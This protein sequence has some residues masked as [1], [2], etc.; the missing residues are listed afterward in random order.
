MKRTFCISMF[1]QSCMSWPLLTGLVGLTAG[2]KGGDSSF[3]YLLLSNSDPVITRIELSYQDSSIAKGT[4]TALE[5]TAIFDNGTNQ[6]ITDSTSIVSDFGSLV[7]YNNQIYL[8]PNVK[9]NQAARFNYDGT[10]PESIFFSFTKDKNATNRAS[11]RDGGIPVPIGHTGCTLNSADI[12][13]GCGPDNEDGRG[14]FA[15]GSLDKKSHIFIAGSKPR[16]F[17]YLYYSSDTDTNLNFKYIDMG[18]IT[19]LATAGTSSIA[20][21]DDR[22]HV[23][24]AKRNQNLNAPDFGKITFNTSDSKR[25]T[26]GNNCDASDGYRGNRFRIDRMP[27]FGGGSQDLVSSEKQKIKFRKGSLDIVPGPIVHKTKV[28]VKENR[29]NKLNN[30][31]INWGYYVGIDSLFVFKEKLYAPN[32]GFPNSLHNGSIIHSTSANPSPCEEINRCSSWKDTAPRSNPKWHNSPHNNWFSLE[33]TKY[34]DLIPADKAFSQFA[35]FNGRLYV[36]RTICVTKEDHSGLRQSLQTVKGC[37]DGSYTNRRPQLWKCDPTLTGDTTTCEAEDWSLVGDNGTGFTN[38]GD[39]SNHSMTMVVASGSYLY[40]GF[41]NENGIQIWRTN[42]ENPGSSSHNWEPIGIGGL[43]DVTN[44]QIY[45]AI[46]GMN[47]GV[48]FVYISV[49]SKDQPV[50]IYRQQNQ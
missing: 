40:V 27:Y 38:F 31:S 41:D 3:F 8:G 36:T 49:G 14:V 7:D 2:K 18:E 17:N 44:R 9:G 26:F 19:G 4:S 21:L 30:S 29:L 46:S 43:R 39:D 50:K 6:N 32:G 45:S 47:F 10:F 42:L 5:V 48:N 25:C 13:T 24:F 1:F 34:R 23:G 11:S 20:V 35:E 15:T 28:N 22:I 37:T 16:R 12:T 33:L